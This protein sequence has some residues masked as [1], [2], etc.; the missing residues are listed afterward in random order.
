MKSRFAKK[1]DA[2]QP[3]IVEALRDAGLAVL[4]LHTLG[5]G[6][7]DIL[8][9]DRRDMLLVEIKAPGKDLQPNQVQ[10]FLEWSGKQPFVATTAE[11]I[12]MRFKRI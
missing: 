4:D 2:N 11:E 12:L 1:V 6:C 5:K 7:P 9:S 3:E 10:W 8:V